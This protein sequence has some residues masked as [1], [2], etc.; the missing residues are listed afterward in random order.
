MCTWWP[1]EALIANGRHPYSARL[2]SAMPITSFMQARHDAAKPAR[3]AIAG[4]PTMLSDIIRTVTTLGSFV[5]IVRA[6]VAVARMI[7]AAE[8]P[9][10]HACIIAAA[11]RPYT[12]AS[13]GGRW[14]R[15]AVYPSHVE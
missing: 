4:P 3:Y 11:Q 13:E 8:I 6:D 5:T 15:V 14:F 2:G 9:M 12:L 1:T 10:P 7:D